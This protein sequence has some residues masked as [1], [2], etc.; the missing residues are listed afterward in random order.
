M[1]A[2]FSP[3]RRGMTRFLYTTQDCYLA[4]FLLAEGGVL[5]TVK[6]LSP[7]KVDFIF[8]A[9]P[10]LHALLR[11]YWR[12]DLVLLVPARLFASFRDLKK[13]TRFRA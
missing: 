4:S 11:L 10:E 12:H 2:A 5:V 9:G 13:L 8:R 1:L 7:K 3:H 6:R